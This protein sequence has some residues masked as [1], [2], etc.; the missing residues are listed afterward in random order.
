MTRF[1]V[2]LLRLDASASASARALAAASASA[3]VT[4][5]DGRMMVKTYVHAATQWR[6]LADP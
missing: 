1:S 3:C 5:K 4:E 2:S 6:H